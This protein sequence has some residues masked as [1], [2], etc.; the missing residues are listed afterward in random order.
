MNETK[1]L[2]LRNGFANFTV[3][4]GEKKKKGGTIFSN[5][6][7]QDQNGNLFNDSDI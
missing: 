7:L 3:I 2:C 5:T 6:S 4:M 1:W